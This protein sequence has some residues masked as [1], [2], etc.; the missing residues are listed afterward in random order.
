MDIDLSFLVSEYLQC[1][2]DVFTVEDFYNFLRKRNAKITRAQAESFL[3]TSEYVFALVNNEFVTRAGAFTDRYFS[4]KLTKEEIKKGHF[5]LGHRCMPFINPEISPDNINICVNDKYIPPV[6]TQFSLNL[7]MDTYSFYGEGYSLSYILNDRANTDYKISSIVTHDLPSTIKLTSWPLDIFGSNRK[8]EYGDRILCKVTD[9]SCNQVEVSL[10][11]ANND[12]LSVSFEE[13]EREEWYSKFET[14]MLKNFEKN[15]PSKSIEEQLAFM[16][17]ENNEDLCQKSCGSC[18]EIFAHSNKISFGSFGVESRLWRT[19]EIVPFAGC[20]NGLSSSD[21]LISEISQ[22]FSP[23]VIDAYLCREI[24]KEIS[25]KRNLTEEEFENL[26]YNIFPSSLDLHISERK[27]LL[28]NIKKRHDIIFK[29]FDKDKENRIASL[30]DYVLALFTDVST[31]LCDIG[32]SCEKFDEFPQQDLVILTQLYGNLISIIEELQNPLTRNQFPVDD[33]M[34]SLDGMNETFI[35]IKNPLKNTL[36]K[37][38]Y[39]KVNI[40]RFDKTSDL[41]KS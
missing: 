2:L 18:E 16:F 29:H 10:R 7:A 1:N 31:L 11:K 34:V 13:M 30:R 5:I 22:M 20:W 14:A 40:K 28:L 17:L 25:K 23:N 24:L 33:T 8:V 12:P 4:F 35:E 36:K 39:S 37:I 38:A 41:I 27:S 21:A 26:L 3:R 19:G 9:W 15:G 32:C 6:P